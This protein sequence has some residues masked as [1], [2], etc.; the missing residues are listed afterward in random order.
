VPGMNDPNNPVGSSLIPCASCGK[1]LSSDAE[2]CPACGGPNAW[3][4]PL[5][6]RVIDHLNKLPRATRYEA[7]GHRLALQ[8]S[9]QTPRQAFGSLLMVLGMVSLV[10]GIL[11]GPL[12]L[13]GVMAICVGGLLTAFGLSATT[14]HELSIDLRVPGCVVGTCDTAFWQDVL[15]IVRSN[16]GQTKSGPKPPAEPPMWS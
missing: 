8:C 11:F 13:I 5:L 7:Q 16:P 3:V 9:Y 4:H 2:V 12:V 1:E 10:A 14:R 15:D 6:A